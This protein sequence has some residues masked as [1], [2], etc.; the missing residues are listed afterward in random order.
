WQPSPGMPMGQAI[1]ANYFDCNNEL[2]TR[3]LTWL[4]SIFEF[5]TP[6]NPDNQ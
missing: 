1:S 3:L 5:E 2:A 6:Q 4:Q